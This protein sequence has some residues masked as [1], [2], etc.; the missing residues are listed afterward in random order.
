MINDHIII[1]DKSKF[2]INIYIYTLGNDYII[3]VM[4][5]Y[6]TLFL[7]TYMIRIYT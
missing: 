2:E 4:G 6:S 3:K 1:L 5:Y 7:Y